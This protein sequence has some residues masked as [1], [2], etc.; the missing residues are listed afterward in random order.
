MVIDSQLI[1]F[2]DSNLLIE[3]RMWNKDKTKIKAVMWNALVHFN[4]MKQKR[5]FHSEELMKTFAAVLLPIEET[6]FAD[7]ISYFKQNFKASK[8]QSV[9]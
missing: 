1:R 3:L 7:R 4:L 9:S 8:K 5:D 6:I 2:D